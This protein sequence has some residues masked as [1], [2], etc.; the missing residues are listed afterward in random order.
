MWL[1]MAVAQYLQGRDRYRGCSQ[2]LWADHCD[3]E[4][5]AY[6]IYSARDISGFLR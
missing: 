3:M 4:S 5:D 6:K 2:T 1:N